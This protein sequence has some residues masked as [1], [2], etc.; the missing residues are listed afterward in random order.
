LFAFVAP[1]AGS[2]FSP[3]NKRIGR[4]KLFSKYFQFQ[5]QN[6]NE[7]PLFWAKSEEERRRTRR[8]LGDGGIGDGGGAHAGR[9]HERRVLPQRS[10]LTIRAQIL[11]SRQAETQV[12]VSKA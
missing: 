12:G 8:R 9:G 10:T 5:E 6:R 11:H 4:F 3:H 7:K 1:P 2:S